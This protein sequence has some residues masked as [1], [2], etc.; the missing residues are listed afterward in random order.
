MY[1]GWGIV[2]LN[3]DR[4]IIL[5]VQSTSNQILLG[6][7]YYIEGVIT[8][9][10]IS[11]LMNPRLLLQYMLVCNHSC[12]YSHPC[13]Y[14]YPN[15]H[16]TILTANHQNHIRDR[17]KR[18]IYR[19]YQLLYQ[20]S[21]LFIWF[22]ISAHLVYFISMI[23]VDNLCFSFDLQ[24]TL[25]KHSGT[26]NCSLRVIASWKYLIRVKETQPTCHSNC[27]GNSQS[28]HVSYS[29]NYFGQC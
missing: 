16:Q 15:I 3:I 23:N 29:S 21:S 27:I 19:C 25:L 4:C 8:N 13:T 12:A 9:L 5:I 22:M 1:P 20:K 28:N 17:H 18:S 11:S 6:F 24:S 2:G 7:L 14:Y 10:Q 26:T